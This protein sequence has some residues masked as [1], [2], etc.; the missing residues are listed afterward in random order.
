ME[1]R[2]RPP[3]GRTYRANSARRT[4]G[5]QVEFTLL[6]RRGPRLFRFVPCLYEIRQT[7]LFQR[8]VPEATPA[9]RHGPER[10][11][12]LDRHP[13]AGRAGREA[14]G[15]MDRAVRETS[16]LETMILKVTGL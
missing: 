10:R 4:E 13:R 6:R 15:Q 14:S 16:R 9:R 3:A 5:C 1:K 7:H 11:G 12:A 8:Q 2:P